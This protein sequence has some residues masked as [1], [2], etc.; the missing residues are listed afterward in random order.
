MGFLVSS[1]AGLLVGSLVGAGVAAPVGLTVGFWCRVWEQALNPSR[2]RLCEHALG[3]E[4][5]HLWVS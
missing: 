4:L 3:V 5:E 1:S 2:A